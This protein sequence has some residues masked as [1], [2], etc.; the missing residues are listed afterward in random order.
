V[1]VCLLLLS[2]SAAAQTHF[3]A[4]DLTATASQCPICHVAHSSVQITLVVEPDRA[5]AIIDF[6]CTAPAPDRKSN[7]ELSWHFSRPPPIA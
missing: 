5:L 1:V 2:I 6:I 7:F 4:D 3:H